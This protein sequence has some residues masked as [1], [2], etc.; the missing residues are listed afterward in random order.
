M[1]WAMTAFP[2]DCIGFDL[3]GTLLDTAGD[4]GNALNHALVSI[5]RAAIP[6]NEIR[7]LIGGGAGMMLNRGLMLTG[8]MPDHGIV[9]AEARLFAYYEAHIAVE[10]RP[11]PGLIAALDRLD[12]LGVRYATVTNKA[13][14]RAVQVLRETGLLDR[15]ACVIGGDTLG[16][17]NAKPS[18]LP[19]YE[20]IKRTG[21]KRAAFVG[22]TSFDI[23]AA[24]N[25]GIPS[26]LCSFG[27][28]DGTPEELGAD[29][30]IDHY[31][32]LIATLERLGAQIPGSANGQ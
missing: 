7:A 15:M 30:V 18:P 1:G 23:G 10:T 3:D 21:A 19:I 20:M 32:D 29:A 2:F 17:E 5:G 16:R 6:I 26:I 9:E 31:D 4:L 8:G 12:A 13:E 25:A 24:R 11:Y 22:D 27:Y 14:A 28:L